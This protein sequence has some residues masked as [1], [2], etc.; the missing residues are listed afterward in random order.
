M[1]FCF[2]YINVTHYVQWILIA[3]VYAIY[4]KFRFEHCSSTMYLQNDEFVHAIGIKQTILTKFP[5]IRIFLLP[6]N[7]LYDDVASSQIQSLSMNTLRK[8][9]R[10]EGGRYESYNFDCEF[11]SEQLFKTLIL[12]S[13]IDFIW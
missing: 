12:L 6:S 11:C 13:T 3:H 8:A 2:L 5:W 9:G 1:A 4:H 7:L 10:E